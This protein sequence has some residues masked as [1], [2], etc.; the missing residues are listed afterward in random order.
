MTSR[1]TDNQPSGVTHYS[2]RQID[3][4]EAYRLE[5]FAHTSTKTLRDIPEVA[6]TTDAQVCFIIECEENARGVRYSA[7]GVSL[8]IL[9]VDNWIIPLEFGDGFSLKSADIQAPKP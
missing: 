3:D 7:D 6:V 5:A 8:V 2:A 1:K 9:E 4:S